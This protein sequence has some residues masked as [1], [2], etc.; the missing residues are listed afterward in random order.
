MVMTV[1]HDIHAVLF[2]QM[3]KGIAHT[4]AGSMGCGAVGGMMERCEKPGK[5]LVGNEVAFQPVMLCGA[6]CI[7]DVCIEHDEVGI[8][9]VE[10]IISFCAGTGHG[11][12]EI[13]EVI[14]CGAFVV[15]DAWE[16]TAARNDV[17]FRDKELRIPIGFHIAVGHKISGIYD[18]FRIYDLYAISH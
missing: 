12:I 1:E 7:S 9:I 18:D 6:G 3:A 13:G 4:Q 8:G 15:A 16:E 14:G 11:E 10:G 17:F 5:V 2:K